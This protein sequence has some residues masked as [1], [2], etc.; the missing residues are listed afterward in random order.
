MDAAIGHDREIVFSRM[1]IARLRGIGAVTDSDGKDQKAALLLR[2]VDVDENKISSYRRLPDETGPSPPRSLLRYLALDMLARSDLFSNVDD[3]RAFARGRLYHP[4][5]DREALILSLGV[6]GNEL[7]SQR[8]DDQ[9]NLLRGWIS[10][11]RQRLGQSADG[12]PETKATEAIS[13]EL[14]ISHIGHLGTFAS[15]YGEVANARALVDEILAQRGHFPLTEGMTDRV[16]DLAVAATEA[17][18]D[19]EPNRESHLYA[20]DP[21]PAPARTVFS[22]LD[23]LLPPG[24]ERVDPEVARERMR[25]L[26]D[27]LRNT[28]DPDMACYLLDERAYW[29][30]DG[31]A[32]SL[33][34][35]ATTGIFTSYGVIGKSDA[36][37]C[38]IRAATNIAGASE[39]ARIAL[40]LGVLRATDHEPLSDVY[41]GVSFGGGASSMN[42]PPELIVRDARRGALYRVG[43][44]PEW[45][46]RSK[47]LRAW[48]F[49]RALKPVASSGRTESEMTAVMQPALDALLDFWAKSGAEEAGR[50]SIRAFMAMIYNVAQ[51]LASSVYPYE[52]AAAR[53]YAMAKH[54]VRFGMQREVATFFSRLPANAQGYR[55]ERETRIA[56]T[57]LA[58]TRGT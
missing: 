38:R 4:H 25:E 50:A 1:L 37:L 54:A 11:V 21:A 13:F 15:R 35:E 19:L 57:I 52:T 6:A 58:L 29:V 3:A 53:L 20:G 55:F 49:E 40:I 12:R 31:D 36:V 18:Y 47:E 8:G 14:V 10:D 33:F 48:L 26:D 56:S 9:A 46:E 45:I 22:P 16:N 43:R 27:E 2:L 23:D 28:P 17:R 24:S 32:E 41:Y 42:T 34:R 5:D 39:D 7:A 30:P 44:H 51:H